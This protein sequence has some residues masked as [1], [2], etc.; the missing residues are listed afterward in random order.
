M[1]SDK[2]LEIARTQIGKMEVPKGSNWGPD[3]Q[4]YLASAGVTVP[5]PWC[6]AFVFWCH[7]EAANALNARNPLYRT[8]GVMTQWDHAHPENRTFQPKAGDIFIMEFAHGLGHTGIVESVVG[9]HIN[10]IEGNT[11]DDGSREGYEVARRCRFIKSMKGF[12]HFQ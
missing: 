8:A 5:A 3:V 12:L 6:M 2:V 11:N 1:F 4:K 10:T 7:N 9:D